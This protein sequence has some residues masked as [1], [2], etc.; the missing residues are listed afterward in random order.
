MYIS[1]RCVHDQHCKPSLLPRNVLKHLGIE[2]EQDSE[3]HTWKLYDCSASR[4]QGTAGLLLNAQE[5]Y[6]H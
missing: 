1:L 4:H 6:T 5:G 3:N 2:L